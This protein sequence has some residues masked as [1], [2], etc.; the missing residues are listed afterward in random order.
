MGTAN[1]QLEGSEDLLK[2]A[3]GTLSWVPGYAWQ[4][5]WRRRPKGNPLHL[6]IALADHFE[7]SF[8][9]E[10][11]SG[12]AP[13]GV[14]EQRLEE[15]CQIY[16]KVFDRWRD[17]SGF[18]FVHTYFYPAEQYEHILVERLAEHCLC[19]WGDI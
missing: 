18:P 2:K 5:I 4:R 11:P 16:P 14:Q 9:P 3:L 10:N 7:P 13:V 6:I 8:L 12:F 17:S 15:W 1:K 19:G